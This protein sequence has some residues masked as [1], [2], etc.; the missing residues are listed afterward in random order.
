MLA[1]IGF[2]CSIIVIYLCLYSALFCYAFKWL[3]KIICSFQVLLLRHL[4]GTR[5]MFKCTF[6]PLLSEAL[7]RFLSLPSWVRKCFISQPD[8]IIFLYPLRWF[9]SQPQFPDIHGITSTLLHTKR[10]PLQISACF[11][12]LYFCFYETRSH[13]VVQA[14][15]ELT[16]FLLP[17]PPEC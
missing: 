15:L 1:I 8:M 2:S 6:S 7:L 13:F 17:Q 5:T 9:F 11:V 16:L 4:C 10:K 3:G 12:L 14:G